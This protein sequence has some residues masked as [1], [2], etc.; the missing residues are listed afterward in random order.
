MTQSCQDVSE[1][2]TEF[3]NKIFKLDPLFFCK[4][5]SQEEM[6]KI[7][8]KNGIIGGKDVSNKKRWRR[9]GTR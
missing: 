8:K 7:L 4:G 3:Y 6:N 5:Y 2:D 1:E 9:L